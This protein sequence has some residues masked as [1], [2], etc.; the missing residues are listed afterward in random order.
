MIRFLNGIRTFAV[1]PAERTEEMLNRGFG[2]YPVV[3]A[4][5][6]AFHHPGL[7]PGTLA[8]WGTRGTAHTIVAH[9]PE[10]Y[11]ATVIMNTYDYAY[12]NVVADARPPSP[13]SSGYPAL[14]AVVDA[15]NF[16]WSEMQ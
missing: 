6:T 7:W 4:A 3:T 2:W 5:G 13:P 12:V 15:F 14:D 9:L 1:L 8:A 11:D 10:G 16:Y